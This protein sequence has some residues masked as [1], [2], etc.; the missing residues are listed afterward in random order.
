MPDVIGSGAR[1]LPTGADAA[2]VDDGA[3]G[4]FTGVVS[5]ASTTGASPAPR[6]AS[7]GAPGG[8]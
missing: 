8:F 4:S 3:E 5:Y 2:D 6:H 1:R 7:N